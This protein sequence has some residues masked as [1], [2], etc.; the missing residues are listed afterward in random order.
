[1]GNATPVTHRLLS[2]TSLAG[3]ED[4]VLA[5]IAG[6]RGTIEERDRQVERSGVYGEYPAIVR[7]YEELF[8]VAEFGAEAI[9]RATFLV[10]CG[11]VALPA[12]TGIAPLPDGTVRAVVQGLND[13]IRSGEADD[14]QL[15]MLAWY[16]DSS[17]DLFE[18]YGATDDLLDAA[19]SRDAEAWRNAAITPATMSLRGQMGHYWL[20]LTTG[21][22]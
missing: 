5:S 6:A 11:A 19:A 9:K 8:P 18:L 1:M 7:A 16:H 17:P 2:L 21:A 15:W 14:E 22:R 13:R 20:E 10:W 3:W 12:V 4:A